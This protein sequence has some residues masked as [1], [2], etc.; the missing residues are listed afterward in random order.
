[1]KHFVK[2]LITDRFIWFLLLIVLISYGQILGM[3]V[4]QDDNA[5]FFK[6]ANIEG[7]AGYLGAG[8]IGDGP[9]KYTVTPY[10]PIYWLFGFNTFYYFGFNLLLY[11]IS[12]VVV[13]K[14]FCRLFGRF[15]GQISG[16]LYACGFI[17]SDG[18]IR[19]FN[20][21]ITSVSVILVCLMIGCYWQYYLEQIKKK[22]PKM[23]TIWF[24]FGAVISY[25]LAVELARA[26]THYLI[27]AVIVFE[28]LFL[29]FRQK[30][31]S[32]VASLV[33]LIPFLV[34]FYGYFIH[35]A[36]HRSGSVG[37]VAVSLVRGSYYQSYGF[38]ASLSNLEL[39][40]W[41]PN[42]LYIV[43]EKLLNMVG[44][45]GALLWFS[46]ILLSLVLIGL[47]KFQP[48]W[49]GWW[50]FSLG[51][52]W[53]WTL[54]SKRIF[55]AIELNLAIFEI[56]LGYLGGLLLFG[57]GLVGFVF[58]VRI[59]IF[60]LVIVLANIAAYAAYNP[61]VAYESINRYLAHSFLAWVGILGLWASQVN[62]KSRWGQILITGIILWGV[63]NLGSAVFYQQQI[64][65]DR[66]RPARQFY[67]S[68]KTDLP[69]LEK[70]SALYFD[71]APGA[72]G[73]FREAFSVAQMPETTAI[74]WRYGI[75]RYDL[76]LFTNYLDFAKYVNLHQV[77]ENKRYSYWYQK[78]GL[79]DTTKTLLS[80]GQESQNWL[81]NEAMLSSKLK[82][83]NDGKVSVGSQPVITF[84]LANSASVT[85]VKVKFNLVASQ[86]DLKSI[87]FPYFDSSRRNT[88]QISK[89]SQLRQDALNYLKF[90]K[91]LE[92][93]AKITVNNSWQD[94]VVG[95]ISDGNFNTVWQADRIKWK[96]Q[97]GAVTI[98]MGGN[99]LISQL[100]W[101][102][103]YANNSPVNY[104][105]EVSSDGQSFTQVK[106]VSLRRRIEP[107]EL[108]LEQFQPVSTRYVRLIITNTLNNDAPA[109]SEISV[110]PAELSKLD[111]NLAEGF[112]NHPFDFIP[113]WEVY[114]RD[115]IM[116]ENTGT[117]QMF[118]KNN[119]VTEF[120][121]SPAL[122]LNI[123]YD[124]L[125]HNYEVTLPAGGTELLNIRFSEFSV[126]GEIVVKDLVVS[127]VGISEGLNE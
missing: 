19:L 99:Q 125:I 28:L 85:P 35:N 68:L 48:K 104:S 67:E 91:N 66:S 84:S 13:Y 41:L 32:M 81:A 89:D 23:T 124:G 14:L 1:M 65:R 105:I 111:I 55:G 16:F 63:I 30:T 110:V 7:K 113:S 2:S 40:S 83:K 106:K 103:G 88:S 31:R 43:Q 6:L 17:A 59:Y 112:I 98:D 39:A 76:A 93:N 116:L 100:V 15:G 33:R 36:D 9:Y 51:F 75:D 72:E 126:P 44:R 37:T 38:L 117:S 115:M 90:K 102:N 127:P 52:L 25:L 57:A 54:V 50:V 101:A 22:S 20:S 94:R 86:A 5:L 71:V 24:Y 79:T 119:K 97:T 49:R 53:I 96:D 47:I 70:G 18:Y 69:H 61:V 34:V 74:A 82:I 12:T 92:K 122:K 121:T 80:A 21:V 95:N 62:R 26:R 3:Y 64:L 56:Y 58:R 87:A 108:Q 109:I 29:T 107:N 78:S 73:Y 114:N 4:W 8:P 120:Q 27:A 46:S 10:I 45:G 11:F 118:W 60:L 42:F 77:P 123:R